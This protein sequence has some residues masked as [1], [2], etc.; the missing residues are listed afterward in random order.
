MFVPLGTPSPTK[1]KKKEKLEF[2]LN[3]KFQIKPVDYQFL[4]IWKTLFICL[5]GY[6]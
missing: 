3:S 6:L 5:K 2:S 4:K 1:K